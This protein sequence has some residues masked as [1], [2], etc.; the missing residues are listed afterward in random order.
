MVKATTVKVNFVNV[1]SLEAIFKKLILIKL[2]I[3]EGV[4]VK[5]IIVKIGS[6]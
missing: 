4:F 5:V 2:F 6:V 3:V 1:T